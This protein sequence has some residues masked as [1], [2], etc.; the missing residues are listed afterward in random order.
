MTDKTW[1]ISHIRPTSEMK[2]RKNLNFVGTFIFK[3]LSY[4]WKVSQVVHHS[5]SRPWLVTWKELITKY[6]YGINDTTSEITWSFVHPCVWD[7]IYVTWPF[8]DTSYVGIQNEHLLDILFDNCVEILSFKYLT[9]NQNIQQ[10]RNLAVFVW[11][12]GSILKS[13]E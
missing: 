9:I 7:L 8:K 5:L 2:A 1:H 12:I 10:L 11:Y 3:I 4:A 6:T 13:L